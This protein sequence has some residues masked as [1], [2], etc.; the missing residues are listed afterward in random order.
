[1]T[2]WM[3]ALQAP[4]SMEFSRQ[5][6]WSGLQFPSPEYLPNPG[7]EL[8]VDSLPPEPPRKP[9]GI[10]S[11][12]TK[13]LNVRPET[14]KLTEENIDGTLSDI[15]FSHISLDLSL[16]AKGIKGKN[17]QMETN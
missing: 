7:I 11:E 16:Q 12:W 15:N 13:D 8:Q 10:N 2:P 17:K 14:I 5:K 3:T 4:L 1:M 6:Y 9:R